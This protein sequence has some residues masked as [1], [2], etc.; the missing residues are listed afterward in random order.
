MHDAPGP[1]FDPLLPPEMAQRC[2]YVGEQKAGLDAVTTFVLACMAGAFIAFGALFFTV[3]ITESTAGY[4][5]TRLLGGVAFSLGLV[6]VIIGGAE[7]FTGNM[8]IVMAWASRRVS[9]ARLLRNWLLVYSGNF[10]GAVVTAGAVYAS[11]QWESDGAAA[12]GTA[13]KIAD[14]KTSLGFGHAVM[15]GVLCNVLVTLAVWLTFSARNNLD[16]VIGIVFP[17]TAFVAAGL[18]HSVANMYF[19]P[20]GL[21][22]KHEP[23]AVSAS[24][25]PDAGLSHL[26]WY[27]FLANNLLPVTVGNIIGG[28]VLVAGVYWFVYLRGAGREP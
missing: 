7:L 17:I 2:E 12:G 24:G 9:T 21:F 4:G 22:L 5:P 14:A 25:L 13:L 16:K 8:L 11:G 20:L 19:I 6:L 26:T 23:K 1:T 3:V 15:L 18:E 28:G 27:D 10:V